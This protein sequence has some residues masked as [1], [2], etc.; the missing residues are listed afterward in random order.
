MD[1]PSLVA[2]FLAYL[3]TINLAPRRND[4]HEISSFLRWLKT[5]EIPLEKLDINCFYRYLSAGK[6]RGLKES[7]LS[8]T[9]A[10]LREFCRWGNQRRLFADII[11]RDISLAWLDIRGGYPAYRGI[12]RKVFCRPDTVRAYLRL[13]FAKELGEYLEML[14]S[15]GYTRIH[16]RSILYPNFLFQRRLLER[17]KTRLENIGPED[18]AEFLNRQSQKSEL[19]RERRSC[20]KRFLIYA[21]N[22]RGLVFNPTPA[23]K[24]DQTLLGRLLQGHQDF[25]RLHHGHKPATLRSHQWH[26][27]HFHRF[28]VQKSIRDPREIN[29]ALIDEFVIERAATRSSVSL[30]NV[31]TSLRSFLKYL[32]LYRH[33]NCDLAGRLYPPSSFSAASRPKY[34]AWEK[35]QELLRSFDRHSPRGKRDYAI[36]MLLACYGLRARE[37]AN[38]RMADLDF[39]NRRFL[40]VQRKGGKDA[41]FPLLPE[42]AGALKDYLAIRPNRPFEQIFLTCTTPSKPLG[43]LVCWAISRRLM[44]R[45]G[46]LRPSQGA[47]LLRHS[48]AKAMLDRGAPLGQI[49]QVLGHRSLNSTLIYTRVATQD[50]KEVADNYANL[51]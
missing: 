2:E 18:A 29:T 34:L 27:K 39:S 24:E 25:C 1:I 19:L 7:T 30:R 32:Y 15:Q 47:Y 45:F 37:I 13:P 50:L 11:T 23:S 38:L 6:A 36:F 44:E 35:I 3:K 43:R 22:Q 4:A 31:N 8:R 5:S 12:F 17:G 10:A 51:L 14:L 48:F 21:F 42:A 46:R 20:I 33:I 28:L 16:A 49:G 41:L 26:L 9:L 40:L